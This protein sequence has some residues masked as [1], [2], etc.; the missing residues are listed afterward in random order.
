[1]DPSFLKTFLA[2]IFVTF[3]KALGGAAV[4]H[5][6]AS[7]ASASGLVNYGEPLAGLVLL[8]AGQG[9]SWL[10]SAKART[11]ASHLVELAKI[12]VKNMKL[13]CDQVLLSHLPVSGT[14]QI[15]NPKV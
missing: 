2:D 9:I 5:H 4:A 1:M 7:P 6:L 15:T 14:P 8:G 12:E 11:E 3:L 10:R 13:L